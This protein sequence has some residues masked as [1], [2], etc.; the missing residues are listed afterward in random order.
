MIGPVRRFYA[1]AMVMAGD[2]GFVVTLDGRP[3]KTPAK[4]LMALPTD[5]LAAAIAVEWQAQGET[6]KPQTMPLTRLAATALDRVAGH[7]E[8][9]IDGIAA[10]GASDLLCYRAEAPDELV[11]RQHRAWQPLLDWAAEQ[12]GAT[13]HVT[14]GVVPIVQPAS[15]LA[16][17]KGAVAA[18]ADLPL[19]ALASIVQITG[20]LIIGLALAR[21]R[22]DA[23][24]AY[25]LAFVDECFQAERWGRDP[26]AEQRRARL[27]DEIRSARQFIDLS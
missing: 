12:W 13:L 26:E 19:T 5:G 24:A 11:A 2:A 4:V 3:V 21:G 8:A 7:R 15:A 25:R 16:A 23:D 1:Q 20:S 14:R 18:F 9:V 27:A 22:I 6:I 17:L 10:Y